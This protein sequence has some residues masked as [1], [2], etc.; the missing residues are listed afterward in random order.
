M[1]PVRHHIDRF[2]SLDNKKVLLLCSSPHSSNP[3]LS[4]IAVISWEKSSHSVVPVFINLV[5][6]PSPS[7]GCV[8]T[9]LGNMYGLDADT[10]AQAR[11]ERS[12]FILLVSGFEQCATPTNLFI[13]NKMHEW[14]GVKV[15][16]T[17]SEECKQ[18]TPCLELYFTPSS[19][20][21]PQIPDAGA[22][23]IINNTDVGMAHEA[24]IIADNTVSLP[25]KYLDIVH[26]PSLT[27][28]I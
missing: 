19:P 10:I 27:L 15:V 6:I 3:L 28:N 17:I 5:D 25:S 21:S 20:T 7:Q 8:E 12:S 14:P 11:Q 1:T 2:L 9:A 23:S 16:F 26:S 18:Q 22:L 13:R 4:Q 24:N